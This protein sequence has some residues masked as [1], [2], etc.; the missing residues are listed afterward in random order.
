VKTL[1]ESRSL[2]DSV[3]LDHLLKKKVLLDEAG[4]ILVVK[5][6]LQNQL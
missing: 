5:P 6:Y 4:L 2:I 1:V 3:Y